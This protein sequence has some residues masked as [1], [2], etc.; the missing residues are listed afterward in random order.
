M[1]RNRQVEG[2]QEGGVAELCCAAPRCRQGNV[3]NMSYLLSPWRGRGGVVCCMWGL[4][5]WG[6]VGHIV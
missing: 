5:D 6:W 3:R 4:L 1:K 2:R